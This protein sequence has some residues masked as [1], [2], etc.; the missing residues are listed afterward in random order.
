MYCTFDLK[1]K[2]GS[3]KFDM[4]FVTGVKTTDVIVF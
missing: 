4:V 1:M 2:L 3:S